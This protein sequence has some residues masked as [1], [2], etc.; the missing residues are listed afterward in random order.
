M[1]PFVTC[2]RHGEYNYL[3]MELLGE[4]ISELRRRQASGRFSIVTTCLLALQMITSIKAVHQLGYLHRDVKPSN[5]AIGLGVRKHRVYMIDFGLSRRYVLPNGKVRPP[6]DQSGFRGTARYASINA[7]LAKDLARR[8][9]LWSLLYML[10]EF[11][12]GILPW[13]RIKDKDQVGEMKI[14]C[15]TPELVADL[16]KEF[17]LLWEHLQTLRYE[18]E[19]DYD[20]L[21]NAF[22]QCLTNAGGS[23]ESSA[24]DW[25]CA[26]N[27]SGMRTRVVPRL[28]DL[29]MRVVAVNLERITKMPPTLPSTVKAQ[30]LSLAL[31]F[32]SKLPEHCIL[33]LLDGGTTDLDFGVMDPMH[34]QTSTTLFLSA[35]V[36][37]PNVLRLN[38]GETSDGKI[39]EL[40]RL[41]PTK[42]LQSLALIAVPK[43]F[44]VNK[45]LRPMLEANVST[46]CRVQLGGESIKD[47]V[48]EAVL[49]GCPRLEMLNVQGCKKVKGTFLSLLSKTKYGMQLK[50]IDLSGC[51][52]NKSG[53]KSLVKYCGN[54]TS[55]RLNPLTASFGISAADL[56]QVIHRAPR[57]QQLDLR[58]D[59]FELDS[60]L[61][62]LARHT[63]SL[64]RL[65]MTGFGITDFGVQHM[66]AACT[67]LR[68]LSLQ[69]GEGISDASL[70]H[71]ASCTSLTSLRLHFLTRANRNLVSEQAL[72]S[73]LVA[74]AELEELWLQNCLLLSLHS[75]PEDGVF[76]RLTRLN[77]SECVQMDDVAIDRVAQLC[78]SLRQ[79]DLSSL[80]SLSSLSL[81]HLSVWCLVLEELTLLNCACFEDEGLSQTLSALPLLMIYIS[82]F[83]NPTLKPVDV[84]IHRHNVRNILT[85]I[86]NTNRLMA[87]EKRKLYSS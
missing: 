58:C 6:R 42:R 83:P 28:T 38:L 15:N 20:M 31:R 72:R 76:S 24:F 45:G 54:L 86:S 30:L 85:G 5:F 52:L 3:V 55:I 36:R 29:S 68:H 53:F 81:L 46:L 51:E 69:C 71:I 32:N 37:S 22:T 73:L 82:R 60:I 25:E 56:I 77:L 48:V 61:L 63:P 27:Q 33:K 67:Q 13:R 79:L 4:N 66:M 49:K 80:N 40:L 87:L 8:D 19:P 17:L 2:G 41:Q 34:N 59:L 74:S 78:P 84:W 64:M 75:F 9:D 62:E 12:N 65:T 57:L 44:S 70:Q 47:A 23:V 1:V 43:T 50:E 18:D 14:R 10:I 16:P 26:S 11:A 39:V 21:T 7:H 35:M